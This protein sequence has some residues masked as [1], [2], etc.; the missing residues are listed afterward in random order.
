MMA[1]PRT[2]FLIY[3]RSEARIVYL[4]DELLGIERTGISGC[5]YRSRGYGWHAYD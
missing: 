4:I 5:A 2:R 1:A 3:W